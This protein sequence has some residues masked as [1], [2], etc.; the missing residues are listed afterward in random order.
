MTIYKYGNADRLDVLQRERIRFTQP[1]VLN[2]PF[3]LRMYFQHIAPESLI[4]LIGRASVDWVSLLTGVY[5]EGQEKLPDSVKANIS[6]E[7]FL[8]FAR[9][10]LETDEGRRML[11]QAEAAAMQAVRDLT[12]WLRQQFAE[13]F[14]SRIGILSFSAIPDNVLMWSHYAA[15]HH[16]LVIGFNERHSYFQRVRR[17]RDDFYWLRPVEYRRPQAEEYL[18]DLDSAD[19]LFRKG[20]EWAYEQE[21]RMLAPLADAVETFAGP[22]GQVHLFPIV[23]DSVVELILGA[24]S[25]H[26]LFSAAAQ[27]LTSDPRYKHVV[28]KKAILHEETG[29]IRIEQVKP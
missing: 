13:R 12:P 17:P 19:I 21:W 29:T 26:A 24:R 8:D 16:G 22:D 7:A 9:S 5:L 25:D 18:I 14:A 1:S 15:Q 28:L 20:P 4:L 23:P 11:W 10:S 2:D 27:L 3:E 6:L